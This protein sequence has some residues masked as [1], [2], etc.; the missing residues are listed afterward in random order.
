VNNVT[1]LGYT[2]AASSRDATDLKLEDWLESFAGRV[3]GVQGGKLYIVRLGEQDGE[4][5]LGLVQSEGKVFRKPNDD[6]EPTDF[7]NA[8]WFRRCGVDPKQCNTEKNFSWSKN[9]AFEQY[10]DSS[11]RIRDELEV[12]SFLL[13]VEDADLTESGLADKWKFPKLKEVFVKKLQLLAEKYDLRGTASSASGSAASRGGA[14]SDDAKTN[15]AKGGGAKGGGAKGGG[16]KG[17]AG[18][19]VAVQAG[20]KEKRGSKQ[21]AALPRATA[22]PI[23]AD[24]R[25]SKKVKRET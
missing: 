25:P 20:D 11:G 14:K 17:R 22:P 9:P 4:L 18:P 3:E 1:H 24:S 12:E 8:L 2:E 13:E 21:A 10:K 7:M 16:A 23:G 15:D 5:K 6:G 19:H